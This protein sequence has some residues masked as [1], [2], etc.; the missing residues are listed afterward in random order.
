MSLRLMYSEIQ[1]LGLYPAVR[2][3][4]ELRARPNNRAT[5]NEKRFFRNYDKRSKNTTVAA[6]RKFR[7]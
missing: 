2:R 1:A 4:N 7:G 5:F 6:H 3:E